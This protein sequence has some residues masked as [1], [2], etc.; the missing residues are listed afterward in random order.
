M[1]ADL[2]QNGA[3]SAADAR[4]FRLLGFDDLRSLPDLS[5]LIDG[6]MPASGL[7]VLY[8]PSGSFKSFLAL[9]WALCVATG[10]PWF[11]H[12]VEPR[13]VVYVAAE[14][15][16]G[17][18][19]RTWA[20]W[21]ARGRPDLSRIRWL[22]EAVN[23]RDHGQ[24]DRARR[25]LASLPER[26]GL[27]VVDTMA[28]TM[29]GGDEN[30]AKD[31]GQF[32]ASV[33]GLRAE[34]AAL[35]VHHTGKDGDDERGSSALRGAAD[36]MAKVERTDSICELTCSKLKDAE[37]WRAITLRLEP[38]PRGSCVLS[39][40]AES[41]ADLAKH[42]RMEADVLAF[43]RANAPAS[44]RAVRAG[45]KGRNDD[46]DNALSALVERAVIESSSRGYVPCPD[47]L[48]TLGH[49]GHPVSGEGRAHAGGIGPKAL[50]GGAHPR[51]VPT[52]PCPDAE[53]TSLFDAGSGT[54]SAIFDADHEDGQ[55]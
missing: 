39:R 2:P 9:D 24:V 33:D 18:K 21:D 47:P 20:W 10:L 25:T 48:G 41:D 17:L 36:L 46:K 43:V 26:P 37:E 23:L 14:G 49:A 13:W 42:E 55:P 3:T 7:S 32:V 15:R 19:A 5:W 29:P 12:T 28:R 53:G 50:P 1:S 54:T 52:E 11:G 4:T 6:L 31:V 22:P 35:V 16:A 30:A 51:T 8:G 27:L 34:D 45:V 44:K 38:Q 40:V